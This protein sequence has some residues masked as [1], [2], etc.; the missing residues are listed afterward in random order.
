MT[1]LT[2]S[3]PNETKIE[4]D[5]FPEIN[6][7]EIA[8]AA[9]KRRIELLKKFREFTKNSKLTEEDAIRLGREVNK[10]LAQRYKR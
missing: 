8:R 7:S 2:L 1:N 3:I 6:W 5:N 9:I 10:K 4:M